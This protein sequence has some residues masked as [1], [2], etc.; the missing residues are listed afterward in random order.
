VLSTSGAPQKVVGARAVQLAVLVAGLVVLGSQ[1]GIS[2]VALAVDAML[3]VGM[4]ILF[5]QARVYVDY[6]LRRLF[7]VP[8][9]AMASGIGLALAAVTMPSLQVSDWITGTVKAAVFSLIYLGI[10]LL[11]ERRE[12]PRYLSLLRQL[13]S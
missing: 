4:A 12:I 2:G 13:L 11:M 1:L 5:W 9:L 6:S 8:G 10:V 7:L 3:V